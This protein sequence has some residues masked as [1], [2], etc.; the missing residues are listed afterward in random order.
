MN[1]L[2]TRPWPDLSHYGLYFGFVTMPNGEKRLV[3]VDETNTWSSLARSMGF[4]QS[5]WVGLWVK[6][7]LKFD[8]PSFATIFPRGKKVSLTTEQIGK[9]ISERILSRQA[10][11]LSQIGRP[12][13][14]S[15]HP[16]RP[17]AK[18]P[19]A[20]VTEPDS[21]VPA[22]IAVRQTLYLGL[23]HLGQDVYESGDGKRFIKV[24]DQVAANEQD[25]TSSP[26]FLRS[27]SN[28]DLVLCASG[29]VAEIVSGKT[30]HSEDF[31]RYL[32]A[33]FGP[34]D[35][36]APLNVASFHSA[37]DRAMLAKVCEIDLGANARDAFLSS[38]RLHEG[39]PSFFRAAGTLPTPL[40]LAAILQSIVRP[41]CELGSRVID[42]AD[43]SSM[44]SWAL[45]EAVTTNEDVIPTHDIAVGGIFSQRIPEKVVSGVRVSRA[46]HERILSSLESRAP[47]GVS[48]FIIAGGSKPGKVDPDFRR[49]LAHIGARYE[50]QGLVDIDAHMI[51][52]GNDVPSR[53]LVIGNQRKEV[54]HT[55][56]TPTEVQVCYDY[57]SLW[58][59]SETVKAIGLGE[60]A[61]FGVDDREQNRWQAPYIPSS[62]V[63]EPGAMCPR[64]LLGPVR[65][66]LA[67]IVDEFGVG[68]DE[69]VSTKLQWDI[70]Q[71]GVYL[72]AE[73]V[74]AV[75]LAIH[76]ID[77]GEGF[78]EADQTGLG[79]GRV[80]AAIARYAK[81]CGHPVVFFTEKSKLFR[82][83][84]RDIQN[85]GAFDMFKTPLIINESIRLVDEKKNIIARTAPREVRIA[86]L[87]ADKIPAE[88]DIVLATYSQFNRPPSESKDIY[89]R[90]CAKKC[91][92]MIS[93]GCTRGEVLSEFQTALGVNFALGGSV[94]GPHLKD[95]I[96][97]LNALLAAN[98]AGSL[99]GDETLQLKYR[100][101]SDEAFE[102]AIRE[103]A[104]ADLMTLKQDWVRSDALRDAVIL[105][106][107]SHN[108]AGPDSQT[109]Q[110]LGVAV[111]NAKA[112]G[113]YSSAT[114]AKGTTNFGIYRRIFPSNIDYTAIG[115]ILERG[116]APLQEILSAMLAEDGKMIRR[117]HDLSNI[118]FELS[119]DTTRK[120]R[121]E[122][123]A[124][125]LAEV[126]SAMSY[127]SGEIEDI[128][129]TMNDATQ[130]ALKAALAA[131]A[132]TQQPNVKV[133][134][135]AIRALQSSTPV[136]GVQY[137]NFSSQ[138]YNITRLFQMAVNADIAAD[139]AIKAL[140]EGRKPVI[141]VENTNE[142]A[143]RHIITN[144]PLIFNGT[145][146]DDDDSDDNDNDPDQDDSVAALIAARDPLAGL[147]GTSQ[148]DLIDNTAP[149]TTTPS[150]SRKKTGPSRVPLFRKITFRDILKRYADSLFY[151]EE[152]TKVGKKTIGQ[153]KV[154][155]LRRP[156][157]ESGIKQV[158]SLIESLPDIP[159]S[160]L[161][162]VRNRI[163]AAGFTIDEIS[164]R[165]LSIVEEQDGTHAIV[166]MPERN[167]HALID[168]FNSG[169]M[170]AIL[171]S[172]S[173]STGIS[174][175]ASEDFADQ[176][177]RE[178]IEMQ[179]AAD[180]V[181]RVQFWGR[182]N[183][184][185]QTCHPIIH[186]VSSGLPGELRLIT[187]QNAA[188]RKMSA[189]ISGNADNSA[190]DE[191]A[192]DILNRVGNE[193]CYRWLESNPKFAKMLGISVADMT[194]N[195]GR[196]SG[197]RFVDRLTGR[198][199]MFD[200]ATQHRIYKEITSEF[201]ALV[202]QYEMEGRNPLK[203]SEH[204]IKATRGQSIV[205]HVP[206]GSQDSVFNTPVIATELIY[207]VKLDAMPEGAVLAESKVA[208]DEL[209]AK[210]GKRY[211]YK[212]QKAI[213][214]RAT[215]L[216]PIM[217]PKKYATIEQAIAAEEPN[218]VRNF[219]ARMEWL[220][221]A[222]PLVRP[223]MF[224]SLA[225]KTDTQFKET[226]AVVDL[227]LPDSNIT[228]LS[229]YKI[230][231]RS[232]YNRNRRT[233]TLSSLY[234]G[235]H[236]FQP[237]FAGDGQYTQ[238][239]MKS[240]LE[241]FEKEDNFT[242]KSVI[243]E[244]NLFKAA[245][246]SDARRLGTAVTYTDEKGI[247]H[248]AILM[249]RNIDLH[250]V[251]NFPI[252]MADADML[253]AALEQ[254]EY[255]SLSNNFK[256]ENMEYLVA[257]RG[258]T[259]VIELV[260]TERDPRWVMESSD[261]LATLVDGKFQGS[262]GTR[263]ANIIS[264]KLQEFCTVFMN[265]SAANRAKP[266]LRADHHEWA[267]AYIESRRPKSANEIAN[268]AIEAAM[269]AN[270]LDS[271]E[272]DFFAPKMK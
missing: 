234:N 124:N 6:S 12:K 155:S 269:G 186:F 117:E 19:E 173:G 157:L 47:V 222:L 191:K 220:I 72:D 238:K 1:A 58:T 111:A 249:P 94:T 63:S 270:E 2:N 138:F 230:K 78:V 14:R 256:R 43:Q 208:Q 142:A 146:A 267:A 75:A 164:G 38:L 100:Q 125:K 211:T 180:I 7:S 34:D 197:T 243:L 61:S 116:G 92:D 172:N 104:I 145:D 160:P 178:L 68:I 237:E 37:L 228:S 241:A 154:V 36:E 168:G 60:D 233:L 91:L 219:A 169:S 139:K 96:A 90:R 55:W 62:Q 126:L 181:R 144:E 136:I 166:R 162:Y 73:Q 18:K 46:D 258:A 79:K 224:I 84:Y 16:T 11:R 184:K 196:F 174:L 30:L 22:D 190:I 130:K 165:K 102:A 185:G 66:A 167:D 205:A 81:L 29:L 131:V 129:N 127:L 3:M 48:A 272:D 248:H 176:S 179:A 77:R 83:F 245:E 240:F 229:E 65:K 88:Y 27:A 264:S 76:A 40:P 114:F 215:E 266:Y 52:P 122:L 161:D 251:K 120:D 147:A 39:R 201:D 28:D 32:H 216:M 159:L 158:Y 252:E 226:F 149:G 217:L 265:L 80:L 263:F 121:N 214:A 26:L 187:M 42:V 268:A 13:N 89:S 262:R 112:V 10:Y 177:Q 202:E 182:V 49:T 242:Y 213:K 225:P 53:I 33:V 253:Q 239:N 25:D 151:A 106:D 70:D 67:R 56:A 35:G 24:H 189:N 140:Q 133:T 255:I 206:I 128:A 254:N 188:L 163:T 261:L 193:V 9:M 200:V 150:S 227:V 71:M 50:I 105:L 110:N 247:W 141:T 246:I 259:Y 103:H 41:R 210:H 119:V 51:S 171:L 192:P 221:E 123:W 199:A 95:D 195:A 135:K 87:Q 101:M 74:D 109:N 198:V 236:L 152:V 15:W 134:Q 250:D 82:D 156:E 260:S 113:G 86:A 20:I 143:L 17:A 108:A 223:G 98:A 8:I 231:V 21:G 212:Y 271:L 23:N 194:E 148:P 203:S 69:Y 31:A 175:H 59:W 64:N 97:A 93:A 54:D 244:G 232:P 85:I 257:R 57:D 209:V 132:T 218:A 137:T 153:R 235:N 44:H 45:P 5:R 99:T 107:E 115:D 183:R 204:D 207:N 4:Q 170:D 118:Q